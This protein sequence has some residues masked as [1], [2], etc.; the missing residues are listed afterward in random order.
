M[1]SL[2]RALTRAHVNMSHDMNYRVITQS[3]QS[4]EARRLLKTEL[5]RTPKGSGPAPSIAHHK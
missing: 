2:R 5:Y 1:R 4:E 3:E